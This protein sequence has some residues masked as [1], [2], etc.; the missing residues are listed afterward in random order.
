MKS[1]V[2]AGEIWTTEWLRTSG[3][4][5][6]LIVV[7][8]VVVSRL[9][10][11]AVHRMRRRH[12]GASGVTAPI[13]VQRAATLTSIATTTIRAVLWTVVVLLVLG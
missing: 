1:L 7:L 12:E 9:G 6:G 8:A 13:G 10:R 2:G 3:V 5:V 11:L 4:R